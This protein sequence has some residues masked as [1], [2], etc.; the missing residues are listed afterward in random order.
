MAKNDK[1][2]AV[3]TNRIAELETEMK[4]ALQRKGKGP[5]YDGPA[6]LRKIADLKA[7]IKRLS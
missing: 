4:S 3:L 7:D 6:T 2:I 1:K 5:A